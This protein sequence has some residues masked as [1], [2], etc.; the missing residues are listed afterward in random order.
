MRKCLTFILAILL[1]T[2]LPLNASATEIHHSQSLPIKHPN[3]VR[4]EN[5][6]IWD[7]GYTCIT[8]LGKSQITSPLMDDAI[9]PYGPVLRETLQE[10]TH[11][12]TDRNGNKLANFCATVTGYY[13]Y[14]EQDAEITGVAGYFSNTT[15]SDLSYSTSFNGRTATTT[16]K[17]SGLAIGTITY[18]ISTSGTITWD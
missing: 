8:T 10:F 13:Y 18:R 16:I 12:I 2:S 14:P 1:A 6:V 4:C 7:S 5:V 9:T 3:E 17:K 11:T 15:Y